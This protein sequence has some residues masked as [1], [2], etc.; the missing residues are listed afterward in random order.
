[1]RVTSSFAVAAVAAAL[2][3][4]AC[5]SAQ[6][7]PAE[8]AELRSVDVERATPGAAA[9]PGKPRREA[10][11][12]VGNIEAMTEGNRDFRR[13]VYTGEHAQLVVMSLPPGEHIGEEVHDVDQFFRVEAG[14]GE[15][16]MGQ[17]RHAIGPGTAILVPSGTRHDVLNTGTTPLALYSIYS[18]PHHRDKVVHRTR[19]EAEKDDEH[20][21]GKTTE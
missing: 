8:S 3:G 18:P 2:S 5:G 11:G 4:L 9:E 16:R 13:V 19:A 1:M 7:Q 15:V 17:T 6:R 21:D 20:F 14:T 10:R 12:F